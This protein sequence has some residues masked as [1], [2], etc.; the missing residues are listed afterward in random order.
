MTTWHLPA[1]I[2]LF[3]SWFFRD[4]NYLEAE[5]WLL[6]P[7]NPN[8]SFLI[9]NSM[10][11]KNSLS[12]SLKDVDKVKHYRIHRLDDDGRYYITN[13]IAFSTLQELVAHYKKDSDQLA[14]RLFD[15]C[16]TSRQP[17]N[18][19]EWE[20]DQNT[21]Q[22]DR[23]LG[24]GCFSEVWSG[25]RSYSTPVAIKMLDRGTIKLSDFKAEAKAMMKIHHPHLLQIYGVCTSYDPIL[26]VTELLKHGAL[27]DYLHT[28]QGKNLKLPGLI[29]MAAQIADGMAYL[30]EHSYIH[31]SLAA[32]NVLVGD[33]NLCKVADFGL[34][35]VIK[36][37]IYDPHDVASF[38]IKWTAP[39]T[40]LHNEFSIKSDV[41]SFGIVIYELLTKGA[42][43][44]RGMDNHQVLD[45][46]KRHYCMPP[47]DNCPDALYNIMFNCWKCEAG[48][49][50]SFVLLNYQLEEYFRLVKLYGDGYI[51]NPNELSSDA[52]FFSTVL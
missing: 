50:P 4:L 30:E 16:I 13:R 31:G 46:M 44:Y 24:G 10:T 18:E 15:P 23:K 19:D 39:E 14:W 40:V 47:P 6:Q 12:L 42:M 33:D 32:R 25:V 36:E 3:F 29:N 38:P 1:F 35:R 11:Q 49:R 22:F 51:V 21:L 52:E 9:R 7:E 2:Y 48:D 41:W 45:A 26:I 5:K 37:D 43:P 28:D 27:L 20:I 34:T 17:G 8:G